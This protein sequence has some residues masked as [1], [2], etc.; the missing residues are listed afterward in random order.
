MLRRPTGEDD[1]LAA[2][3]AQPGHAAVRERLQPGVEA[4]AELIGQRRKTHERERPEA[5]GAA[6]NDLQP[7]IC[8]HAVK[9]GKAMR[10]NAHA[11]ITQP[12][13]ANAAQ[14]RLCGSLAGS[15]TG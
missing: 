8:K 4:R 2:G 6:L 12:G 14:G 5:E 7:G 13:D 10:A 3:S 1:I 11:L 15:R 9:P